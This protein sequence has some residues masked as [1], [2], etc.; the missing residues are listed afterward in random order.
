L[1]VSDFL[2]T[3]TDFQMV[4]GDYSVLQD[5]ASTRGDISLEPNEYVVVSIATGETIA[6]EF[7]PLLMALQLSSSSAIVDTTSP[8]PPPI[9]GFDNPLWTLDFSSTGLPLRVEGTIETLVVPEPSTGLLLASVGL[10]AAPVVA[11]GVRR[12]RSIR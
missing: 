9:E 3:V 5:P 2:H 8:I 10:F 6:D 1:A 12:R 7:A 11:R 4:I